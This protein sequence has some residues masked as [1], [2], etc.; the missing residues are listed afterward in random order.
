MFCLI[1]VKT[2]LRL[3]FIGAKSVSRSRERIYSLMAVLIAQVNTRKTREWRN[4]KVL[5]AIWGAVK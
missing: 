5:V 3:A 4:C 2:T 1:N